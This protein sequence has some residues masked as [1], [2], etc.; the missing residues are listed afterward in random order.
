[1]EG[2]IFVRGYRL[3]VKDR[4]VVYAERDCSTS[5]YMHAFMYHV[6]SFKPYRWHEIS[7]FPVNDVI[8]GL[9]DGTI[10]IA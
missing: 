2:I 4:M 7:S 5:G 10:I 6:D 1:M 9:Q 3:T 8:S